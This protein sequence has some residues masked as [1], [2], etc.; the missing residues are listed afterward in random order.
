MQYIDHCLIVEG[1]RLAEKRRKYY[2]WYCNGLS[3]LTTNRVI[4]QETT[5][6]VRF[7]GH[8]GPQ[9]GR[10]LPTPP[11]FVRLQARAADFAIT[12]RRL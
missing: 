6:T 9:T 2:S 11:S 1:D 12:S 3:T 8:A 4:T 5:T 7:A 10:V